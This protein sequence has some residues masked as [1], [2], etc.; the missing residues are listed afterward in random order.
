MSRAKTFRE[1]DVTRA[2]RAARKAGC[3]PD[4][5]EIASGKVVIV[6]QRPGDSRDLPSQALPDQDAALRSRWEDVD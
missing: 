5:I 3:E 2:V 4:R 6:F 1:E